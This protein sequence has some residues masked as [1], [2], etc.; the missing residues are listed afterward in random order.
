M[1]P[2]RSGARERR[3]GDDTRSPP[4]EE[5]ETRPERRDR[6]ARPAAPAEH[7]VPAEDRAKTPGQKEPAKQAAEQEDPATARRRKRRNWLIAGAVGLVALIGAVWYGVHWFTV[8]RYFVETDDAYTQADAVTLSPQ[9]AGTIAELRVTDNQ[10]VRAG[11]RIARIDDRTYKAQLDQAR[12]DLAAAEANIRNAEAQIELEKAV[13]EQARAGVNSAEAAQKFAEEEADRYSRLVKT[14]AGTVQRSQQAQSDLIQGRAA[15]EKKLG[16]LE[17]TLEQTRAAAERAR[18]AVEQAEINL[19]Y[20]RLV[21]PV[22]GVV[23][24]RSA[25]VGQYVQ[26]GT[27][28][29]TLVPMDEVY[30]VANYKET[31]LDRMH[32]GQHVE[33]E[34]DA[35][36]GTK[37]R[38]RVDSLAPGS[39]AQFALLPPEN[40]TGNFTKIV[41][42]V[43]VKILIDGDD[44][45]KG[46]LR[47]GLSVLTSVDVRDTKGKKLEER[48]P[49]DGLPPPGAAPPPADAAAR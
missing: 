35:Y 20:T 28:L 41:Q 17:T 6:P 18:A 1:A 37:I 11:D 14:G 30:V 32:Q 49:Q 33:L 36:P 13:V 19:G 38:G 24:D 22:D 5:W 25:R 21:A 8:G 34:V 16:V 27:R 4:R 10:R 48:P 42:R 31:Q 46:R 45:L 40:A 7:R 9:V 44:P 39:G 12:A 3:D 2:G 29:L 43:P 26:P 15:E 23:G 47:P